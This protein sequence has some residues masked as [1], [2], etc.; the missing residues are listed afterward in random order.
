MSPAYLPT[1][2]TKINHSCDGWEWAQNKKSP[3]PN[4]VVGAGDKLYQKLGNHLGWTKKATHPMPPKKSH[5]YY[6]LIVGEATDFFWCL[7]GTSRLGLLKFHMAKMDFFLCR[8]KIDN[9]AVRTREAAKHCDRMTL[10]TLF[11]LHF[12]AA[13]KIHELHQAVSVVWVPWIHSAV[14][15]DMLWLSVLPFASCSCL[16]RTSWEETSVSQTSWQKVSHSA[17]LVETAEVPT[18]CHAP[19]SKKICACQIG[20]HL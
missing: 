19:S 2:T 7:W 12:Y 8:P 15:C 9:S 5:R 14:S 18:C 3:K 16:A 4:C 20:F 11:P 10:R 1:F 17:S 13:L 6:G